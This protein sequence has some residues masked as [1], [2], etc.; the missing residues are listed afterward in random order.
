MIPILFFQ[1]L[2][3]DLKKD[4]IKPIKKTPPKTPEKETPIEK[5]DAFEKFLHAIS[6][7]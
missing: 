5:H 1:T 4:R 3:T 7:I 2:Y 6:L